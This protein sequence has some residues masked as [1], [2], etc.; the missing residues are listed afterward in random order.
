[1]Q[2]Q[3]QENRIKPKTPSGSNLIPI[4]SETIDK[5]GKTYLKKIGNTNIY[6]KIQASLEETKVYNILEKFEKTGDPSILNRRQGVYGDFSNI[7]KSPIEIQNII[8]RAEKEFN[9]LDKDVRQAF[10]NDVGMFKQSIMDGSFEEKMQK[11]IKSK[12]QATTK[13]EEKKAEGVNLNE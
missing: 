10:E 2:Y 3:T 7:P 9:S 1:M 12:T 5:Q 13:P 11:F 6:E 4:Y 8:L